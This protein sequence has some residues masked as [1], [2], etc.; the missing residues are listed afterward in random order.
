MKLQ[1]QEHFSDNNNNDNNN[2]FFN[3]C[4]AYA[5]VVIAVY[6]QERDDGKFE[7][8][9]YCLTHLPTQEPATPLQDDR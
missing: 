7:V 1:L 8:D 6:G 4:N 2:F 5:G 9:D 3:V